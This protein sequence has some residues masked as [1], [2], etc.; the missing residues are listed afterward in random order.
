MTTLRET[1]PE[2]TVFLFFIPLL[3]K[4]HVRSKPEAN[5]R[6]HFRFSAFSK[7]SGEGGGSQDLKL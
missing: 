1:L 6:F 5:A 2:G 7:K 4:H 3:E